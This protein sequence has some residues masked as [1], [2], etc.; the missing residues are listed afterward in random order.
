[1]GT[2]RQKKKKK[3]KKVIREHLPDRLFQRRNSWSAFR[4]FVVS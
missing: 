2:V 3:K 1:M 4:Q